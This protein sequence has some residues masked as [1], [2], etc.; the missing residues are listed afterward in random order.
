MM[1]TR[2]RKST[3]RLSGQRHYGL[4]I[5]VIAQVLFKKLSYI[6]IPTGHEI[7]CL[8]IGICT[9]IKTLLIHALHIID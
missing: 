3:L 8:V 5:Q 9:I 1:L 7:T 6:N 2:K 4:L